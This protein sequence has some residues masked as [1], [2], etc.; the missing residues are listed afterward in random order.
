MIFKPFNN[1]SYMIPSDN[2]VQLI[3]QFEGCKL[4]AYQDVRGIWT[5][6]FGTT[7]PGIVEGLTIS[8]N[9]ADAMLKGHVKE[10]GLSLTDFIGQGIPQ[11][12]F[13]AC[14]CLAYNIGTGNFKTSTLLKLIKAQDLKGAA[15]EFLKW[16]HAGGKEIEGL[17]RRREAEMALF[18][19]GIPA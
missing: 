15:Q 10:V 19:R 12:C 6:G 8:Q 2:A 4:E 11:D 3:K 7:G 5:I 9:T 16:D 17:K 13:D 18:L 14:T 1:L